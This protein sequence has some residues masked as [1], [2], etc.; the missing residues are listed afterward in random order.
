MNRLPSLLAIILAFLAGLIIFADY[1]WKIPILS[2]TS[3]FLLKTVVLVSATAILLAAFNLAVRHTGKLR[4]PKLESWLLVG[5]FIIAFGVGLMPEGFNAGA[6]RWLYHW[7]LAPGMAAIFAL[8]PIFLAY[9]LLR[10]FHLRDFGGFLF[11]LGMV[12]TLLGQTPPIA[13]RFPLLAR[14]R[15]TLLSGPVAIAFRGVIL[16]LALGALLAILLRIP[17]IL[18]FDSQKNDSEDQS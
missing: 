1:F 12:I 4:S 18:P 3:Q 16:G 10:R 6:G 5:G 17:N 2:S 11:F 15:Q 13:A 7:L 9:A 8:L 14:A